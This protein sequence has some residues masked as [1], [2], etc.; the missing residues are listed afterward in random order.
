MLCQVEAGYVCN[1]EPSVCFIPPCF[2]GTNGMVGD[3]VSLMA[4]DLPTALV[5]QYMASDDV[6]RRSLLTSY[7][8]PCAT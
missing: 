2:P 6:A 8:I 7:L 1:G 3:T 4:T 5:E